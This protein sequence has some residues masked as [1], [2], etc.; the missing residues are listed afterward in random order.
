MSKGEN[1]VTLAG[2][3]EKKKFILER[4]EASGA[5]THLEVSLGNSRQRSDMFA[6][7]KK[8]A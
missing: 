1:A 8:C 3:R 7:S 6:I 5:Q 4:R 2:E